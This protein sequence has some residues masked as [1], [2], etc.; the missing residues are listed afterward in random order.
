MN[1]QSC[2]ELQDV[3]LS[4]LQAEFG[5]K[6]GQNL[7]RYQLKFVYFLLSTFQDTYLFYF[8]LGTV[9]VKMIDL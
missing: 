3:P 5:N 2:K 7:Q 1:V 8:I 6:M 4:V 9:L